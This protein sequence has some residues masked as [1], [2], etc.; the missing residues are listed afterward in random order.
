MQTTIDVIEHLAS[1]GSD[2]SYLKFFY[3][4]EN[5]DCVEINDRFLITITTKSCSFKV[6]QF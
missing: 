2:I 1:T 3:L 4:L 6:I 5:A